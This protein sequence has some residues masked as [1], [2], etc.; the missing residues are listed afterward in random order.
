MS[1]N[2]SP[3]TDPDQPALDCHGNLKDPSLL[4]L[5]ISPDILAA[6][7]CLA[8]EKFPHNLG[9]KSNCTTLSYNSDKQDSDE[10]LCTSIGDWHKCLIKKVAH[11]DVL[12]QKRTGQELKLCST[13]KK[14]A[15]VHAAFAAFG[16][17]S[18]NLKTLGAGEPICPCSS[19]NVKKKVSAQ[20]VHAK[21][22]TLNRSN[23]GKILMAAGGVG[24]C[25]KL[26]NWQ[27][28]RP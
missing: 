16:I 1:D 27:R 5:D 10:V 17:N 8:A 21:V 23:N 15:R 20:R 12:S 3:H 2:E 28:G 14:S 25:L 7:A 19:C 26:G 24:K 18:N 4:E 6:R 9:Y 22:S 13:T 11:K